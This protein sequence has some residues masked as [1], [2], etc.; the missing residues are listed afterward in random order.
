MSLMKLVEWTL[1]E[2]SVSCSISYYLDF[3]FLV[4]YIIVHPFVIDNYSENNG[5]I[6]EKIF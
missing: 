4:I 5:L 6:N 2:R 1:I 3:S